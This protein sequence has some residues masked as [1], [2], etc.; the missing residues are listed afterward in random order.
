MRG[1]ANIPDCRISGVPAFYWIW[2]EGRRSESARYAALRY[3]RRRVDAIG[4]IETNLLH[5]RI[6]DL[7]HA[8]TGHYSLDTRAVRVKG[9]AWALSF[10]PCAEVRS[11]DCRERANRG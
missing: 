1:F 11:P 7:F 9:R 8:H 3:L 2:L 5:K 4:F 6:L 10:F